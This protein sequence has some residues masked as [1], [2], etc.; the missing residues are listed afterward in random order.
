MM[1]N[2]DGRL[3]EKVTQMDHSVLF[4]SIGLFAFLL[5]IYCLT[6]SGTYTTDDEHLLSSRALTL[7]FD[8]TPGLSR[9]IGNTRV[10]AYS[11][12]DPLHA[13]Q[14]EN[15]EPAQTLIGAVLVNL[16]IHLGIGRIQT[17]FLLN[18]WV[19][20]LTAVVIY[21]TARRQGYSNA[22]GMILSL[23]FGLCTIAF[24]YSKTFFRDSLAM[25]FVACAWYFGSAIARDNQMHPSGIVNWTGI[26][27][28]IGL[29][30]LSKN[31]A[32]LVF[33]VLLLEIIARKSRNGKKFRVPGAFPIHQPALWILGLLMGGG[34]FWVFAV[35]KIP[36]LARFSP[37]YYLDLLRFFLTTPHPHLFEAIAGPW[38]SPGKSIYLFS[39]ILILSIWCLIFEFK[40]TRSAYLLFLCM[41]IA[42]EL[43]YDDEWAGHINWGL[44]YAL[45][46]IPALIL[47]TAPLVK[48]LIRS[49]SGKIGLAVLAG[50][51]LFV[52]IQGVLV[53]VSEYFSASAAAVPAIGEQEMIWNVR[54][55]ILGWSSGWLVTGQPAE[56]AL[57][58]T[59]PALPLAF[60]GWITVVVLCLIPCFTPK[61]RYLTVLAA[62]V[63]FATSLSLPFLYKTDP[64]YHITRSDLKEAQSQIARQY[65]TGDLILL[66]SYGSPVWEYWMNWAGPGLTWSALPYA[67]PSPAAILQYNTDGDPTV[68]LDRVSLGILDREARPGRR[69]WLVL[70]G[71]TAGSDLGIEE[72]WLAGR[73]NPASCHLISGEEQSTRLCRFDLRTGSGLPIE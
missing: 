28:S 48:K 26:I 29:G 14:V 51:S 7:A 68:A 16:S 54:D 12:V 64:A 20:A 11:I 31:I 13:S 42:Q 5:S 45:P 6:Y 46:A 40:S 36:L 34:L 1:Q 55:S 30:S 66:K 72:K 9:V 32:L 21:L 17:L 37:D 69:V 65:H 49:R 8:Q 57:V 43:F 38:I 61:R 58:R 62:I 63:A 71:D 4:I 52:Q 44:R 70:P 60:G 2:E 18:L 53:P 19:T 25:G 33:P 56:L 47:S 22:V 15:I 27:I 41:V 39:P 10:Y 24:P 3:E 67:Y 35:P 59:G 73:S 23:L 50:I